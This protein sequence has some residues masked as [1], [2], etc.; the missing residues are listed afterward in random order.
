MKLLLD[1]QIL[2][3]VA[4]SP[5]VLPGKAQDLL[6]NSDNELF[7]SSVSLWEV[8]IK[9]GLNK[10]DFQVDPRILHQ[11]LVSNDY[12]ELC[13]CGRHTFAV[14]ELPVLHKDPFDRILI[15]QARV[16]GMT[17]LTCDARIAAYSGP[18]LFAGKPDTTK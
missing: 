9:F 16:E 13:L 14:N 11:G 18:I 4:D 6:G 5:W 1:T 15:A 3:W 7:F 8:A 2:I 17:L 10:H 12:Q